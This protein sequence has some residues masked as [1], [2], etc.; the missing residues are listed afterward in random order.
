MLEVLKQK[1]IAKFGKEILNATDC[2]DLSDDIYACTREVVSY[3]TL[4][5][6]FGLVDV[7]TPRVSTLDILSKYVGE[8]DFNHILSLSFEQDE[9][10]TQMAICDR[11]YSNKSLDITAI[12]I[13]IDRLNAKVVVL[14]NVLRELL[15]IGKIDEFLELLKLIFQ[16]N[17]Y[18]S[19]EH[20]LYIGNTVGL[21]I[22]RMNISA[23]ELSKCSA[24]PFFQEFILSIYVDYSSLNG[25]YGRALDLTRQHNKPLDSSFSIFSTCVSEWKNWL[26]GDK[27]NVDQISQLNFDSSFYPILNSRICAIKLLAEPNN[28]HQTIHSYKQFLSRNELDYQFDSY[29]EVFLGSIFLDDYVVFGWLGEVKKKLIPSSIYH[30]QHQQVAFLASLFEALLKKDKQLIDQSLASIRP[31]LF[32]NSYREFMLV[33][34][35]L[36]SSSPNSSSADF[37]YSRFSQWVLDKNREY[38]GV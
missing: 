31:H 28:V 12:F 14:S 22:K 24:N 25:W 30:A 33:L 34:L 1:V 18:L 29:Y 3:N 23:N 37:R 20:K 35:N 11:I 10:T 6:F 21:V 2:K 8:P 9:W 27:I 26:N 17:T 36:F 5:R 16:S 32:R 19:Y 7:R 4:R 38:L 13:S 15:L